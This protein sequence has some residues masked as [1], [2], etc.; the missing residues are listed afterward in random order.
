[1]ISLSTCIFHCFCSYM[2]LNWQL[3]HL[4]F[5][6]NNYL[7]EKRWVFQTTETCVSQNIEPTYA[8]TDW[9]RDV[10]TVIQRPLGFCFLLTS[11]H[12]WALV[13]SLSISLCACIESSLVSP[14]S[15][16]K[17]HIKSQQE[18]FWGGW[19]VLVS[20]CDS[21]STNISASWT[22]MWKWRWG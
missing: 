17:I 15:H 19:L 4:D 5:V 22:V 1:M 10:K 21:M 12:L 8:S 6:G 16:I 18:L 13:S 11:T 2:D 7:C 20:L 3:F 14:S 9:Q